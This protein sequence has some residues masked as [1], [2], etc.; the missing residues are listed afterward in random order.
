MST[1]KLSSKPE[2]LEKSKIVD[3]DHYLQDKS[4]NLI[5]S[6]EIYSKELKSVKNWSSKL[7]IT[8]QLQNS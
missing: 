8:Q 7:F 4:A 5:F 3:L 1:M 2:A 6:Y